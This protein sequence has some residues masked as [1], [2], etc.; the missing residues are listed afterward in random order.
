VKIQED[1]KA[2][3]SDT[4]SMFE[5]YIEHCDAVVHFVGEMTGS[6]PKDFGVAQLLA[7]R[8]DRKTRL[9]PLGTAL[10]IDSIKLIVCEGFIWCAA[11]FRVIFDSRS[12]VR[13]S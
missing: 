13:R 8:P 10:F 1:F 7:R 6:R 5:E 9:P 4:L 2:L 11:A 12:G 3:G